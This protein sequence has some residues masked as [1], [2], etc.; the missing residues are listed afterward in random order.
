ME[1]KINFE[2]EK[3]TYKKVKKPGL[4]KR[5]V[6]RSFDLFSSLVVM[7]L[8]SPFF[9]IF[10][11]IAAIA[12]KGNPFFTQERAGKNGKPFKVI[13]Y[14]SMTNAKDKD[15]NL[16]PNEKRITKFGKTMRK[17]SIDEL[18]QLFNIFFGQMSVVGPRPLHMKYNDRYNEFQKQRLL[19]KPGLTGLAQ[20]SGRNA[21]TWEEKFEKDIEYV[22]KCGFFY[23]LKIIFM[24]I[25]KVLKRESI[26]SDNKVGTEEFMGTK[27]NE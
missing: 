6:K 16:L 23:D 24:T 5:F 8:L 11:P 26:D 12:M 25:G 20:V 10:T 27:S 9:I 22:E 1:E 19:V 3:Q 13:K 14:R 17:L 2:N 15:G 21:I 18:P 4:I 7:L